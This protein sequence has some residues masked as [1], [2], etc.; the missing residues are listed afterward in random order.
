MGIL[1][2]VIIK[3][4]TKEDNLIS[5]EHKVLERYFEKLIDVC[6]FNIDL[7]FSKCTDF[8]EA[9]FASYRGLVPSYLYYLYQV[10]FQDFSSEE[11]FF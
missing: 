6:D 2:Q 10:T 5:K 3:L 11:K 4:S 8:T 9:K 7:I 1:R